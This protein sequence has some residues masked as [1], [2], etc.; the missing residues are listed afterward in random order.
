MTQNTSTHEVEATEVQAEETFTSDYSGDDFPLSER[1]ELRGYG[2]IAMSEEGDF[3]ELANGN[4]NP[5]DYSWWCERCEQYFSE[6]ESN[7]SN[8]GYDYLCYDC[9]EE[10]EEANDYAPTNEVNP[11]DTTSHQSSELGD[12]IR[13]TRGFGIELEC[14]P[15]S[16][17]GHVPAGTSIQTDGSL[18]DNGREFVSP[19]LKGLKGEK[20]VKRLTAALAKGETTVS[21]ACGYHIHLS[22]PEWETANDLRHE[23][24]Q[25]AL[26]TIG[27]VMRE[28]DYDEFHDLR[29]SQTYEK[30]V[31]LLNR[32]PK[33]SSRQSSNRL[34]LKSFLSFLKMY[35]D[36]FYATQPQSRRSNTYC[37]KL[38]HG[39]LSVMGDEQSV[40]S[41]GIYNS[42]YHFANLQNLSE[43]H[44]EI[45]LH[46]GTTNPR[47][48]LEWAN[49]WGNL[50]DY[51][52]DN[53]PTARTIG[54]WFDEDKTLAKRLNRV[55]ELAKL[56]PESREYF[57][58]RVRGFMPTESEVIN[59]SPSPVKDEEGSE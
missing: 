1:L 5:Q 4:Y 26:E 46:A 30:M 49:L 9:N 41:T 18:N 39:L 31:S 33:A 16:E 20:Y 17:I 25:R 36:A 2:T 57:I 37:T 35:E 11:V 32:A 38:P 48:I 58:E 54:L 52:I 29:A 27:R 34:S 45:R 24:W 14:Y 12:I 21:R 13:H 19:I 10:V 53:Q 3:V 56:S 43:G 47:K 23:D 15:Q 7:Y 42:R 50:I 44:I 51:F 6:N 22:T 55:F 8:A 59:L 40:G 28:V